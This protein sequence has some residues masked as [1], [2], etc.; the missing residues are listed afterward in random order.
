MVGAGAT[1]LHKRKR[2][3]AADIPKPEALK[4][5]NELVDQ[6]KGAKLHGY[7]KK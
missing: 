6:T 3:V 7:V 4:A 1:P 5:P 2:A